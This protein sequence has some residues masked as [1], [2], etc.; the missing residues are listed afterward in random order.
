MKFRARA[1]FLLGVVLLIV[2]ACTVS[3]ERFEP[4]TPQI[5][6]GVDDPSLEGSLLSLED[7]QG[8]DDAPSGLVEQPVE[9]AA[10]FDNP[11]P[12]G[13]C[14]AK[15][16]QP[17]PADA[18]IVVFDRS[19]KPRLTTFH[20]AWDLPPG[21]AERYF[22]QDSGDIRPG[23]PAFRSETPDGPQ[24]SELLE[25]VEIPA[26]LA[27]AAVATTS[28]ITLPGAPAPLYGALGLAYEGSRL[29]WVGVFSEKAVRTTFLQD[30]TVMAADKL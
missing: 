16:S 18:A 7:V 14:G 15:I 10:L 30:L 3:V 22:E 24:S 29:T 20:L 25:V 19:E 2:P 11:D 13:P 28:R 8:A 6:Q 17:D 23:C 1:T 4:S 27:D 26:R 9:D 21:E 5:T 12:R